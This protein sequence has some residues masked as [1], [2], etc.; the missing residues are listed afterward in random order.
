MEE[1][2][3]AL[4][5]RYLRVKP[6]SVAAGCDPSL[7]SDRGR[8]GEDETGAAECEAAQMHE[9]EIVGEAVSGAVRGHR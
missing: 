7:R 4:E 8:F 9:M 6:K 2:G 5:L 1:I 3:N